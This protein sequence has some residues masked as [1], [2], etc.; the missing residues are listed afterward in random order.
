VPER[1]F[2]SPGRLYVG[3][4]TRFTLT[5]TFHYLFPILAMGLA[6]FTAASR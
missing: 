6:L 2:A 3:F 4:A 5:I 1:R